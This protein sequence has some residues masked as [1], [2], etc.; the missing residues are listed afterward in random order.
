MLL[1]VP[2]RLIGY[3]RALIV[4]V[5]V[6]IIPLAYLAA[7]ALRF[8]F[9]PPPAE[10]VHFRTTVPYLLGIRLIVFQVLGLTVQ[11]FGH[12]FDPTLE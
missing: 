4:G 12:R 6:A 5:Q 11:N 9:H 10:W 3:R 8:D 1:R 7:F 2:P